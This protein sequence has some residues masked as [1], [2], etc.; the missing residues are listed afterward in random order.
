MHKKKNFLQ[1][2]IFLSRVTSTLVPRFGN[3][4]PTPERDNLIRNQIKGRKGISSQRKV[5]K[6]FQL[7]SKKCDFILKTPWV[8]Y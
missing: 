1:I 5:I 7:L 3:V 8:S 4:R 2:Y 6:L